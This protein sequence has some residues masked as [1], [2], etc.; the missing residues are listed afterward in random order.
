MYFFFGTDSRVAPRALCDY[1]WKEASIRGV[2]GVEALCPKPTQQEESRHS[3]CLWSEDDEVPHRLCKGTVTGT[4]SKFLHPHE[5]CCYT[6]C[7]PINRGV[8]IS[9]DY[10]SL[11]PLRIGDWY[12][13]VYW[14]FRVAK[15]SKM[16]MPDFS[17][18]RQKL[19]QVKEVFGMHN[20]SRRR[21]PQHCDS[22]SGLQRF[23]SYS[24]TRKLAD[25]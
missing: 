19:W 4:V 5:S 8:L 2:A 11:I 17:V 12:C 1:S 20:W 6:H 13:C 9:D 7:M 10:S 14:L 22:G 24:N 25:R 18:W 15:E 23:A 21:P 3:Y 16:C